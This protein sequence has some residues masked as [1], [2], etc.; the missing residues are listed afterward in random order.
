MREQN[1]GRFPEKH[2]FGAKKL[3][4]QVK[5]VAKLKKGGRKEGVKKSALK[6]TKNKRGRSKKLKKRQARKEGGIGR[7][8]LWTT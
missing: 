8:P 6:N 4:F 1:M 7:P 5:K 2:A 3:A